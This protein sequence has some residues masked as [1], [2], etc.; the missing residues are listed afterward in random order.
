MNS[1]QLGALGLLAYAA[2]APLPAVA[3]VQSDVT[4]SNLRFTLTDL[5]PDDGETPWFRF[6]PDDGFNPVSASTSVTPASDGE[7][8]AYDWSEGTGSFEFSPNTRLSLA[9]DVHIAMRAGAVPEQSGTVWAV[10]RGGATWGPPRDRWERR[11]YEDVYGDVGLYLGEY[12]PDFDRDE[13]LWL[14][15]EN[16]T[17]YAASGDFQVLAESTSH[18]LASPV[19]EPSAPAMLAM[20]ACLLSILGRRRRGKRGSNAPFRGATIFT[21]KS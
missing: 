1:H 4:V 18:A 20:G 7:R 8:R 15:F 19:P 6:S 3:Q 14:S 16:N 5:T 2:L 11:D 10:F 12:R 9:V 13:T 17:A 21:M